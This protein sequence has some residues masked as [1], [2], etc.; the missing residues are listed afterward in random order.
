MEEIKKGRR[1]EG[2]E[3]ASKKVKGRQLINLGVDYKP[4]SPSGDY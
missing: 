3:G 2:K 4:L 1:T